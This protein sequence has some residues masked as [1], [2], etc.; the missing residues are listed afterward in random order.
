MKD[1]TMRLLVIATI[2]LAGSASA[3]EL[4]LND[5]PATLNTLRGCNSVAGYFST[6][7]S[8]KLGE[9]DVWASIEGGDR[10][11]IIFYRNKDAGLELIGHGQTVSAAL[12]ELAFKL[13]Q[14]RDDS[15]RALDSIGALLPT[16]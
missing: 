3:A 15:K 5:L 9:S 16:Q 1:L 14:A 4:T 8:C 12:Q 6:S 11:V 10:R 2:L 7:V 13:N